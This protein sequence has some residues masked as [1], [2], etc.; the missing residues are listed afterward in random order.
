[1]ENDRT[2]AETNRINEILAKHR[3]LRSEPLDKLPTFFSLTRRRYKEFEAS[4]DKS[5]SIDLSKPNIWM[6]DFPFIFFKHNKIQREKLKKGEKLKHSKATLTK[7]ALRKALKNNAK[8]RKVFIHER[9]AEPITFYSMTVYR[10]PVIQSFFEFSLFY[11]WTK[12]V[13]LSAEKAKTVFL[14]AAKAPF[15][16]S[17]TNNDELKGLND[18]LGFMYGTEISLKYNEVPVFEVGRKPLY[19]DAV[20]MAEE[21]LTYSQ[22][23][24]HYIKRIHKEELEA[25]TAQSM[26]H[27]LGLK[28]T[29]KQAENLTATRKKVWIKK[30]QKSIRESLRQK[31]YIV[32][33]GRIRK[34]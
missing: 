25:K 1:M 20:T 9:H 21:G 31:G 4:I 8:E 12:N 30:I 11:S 17:G 33:N 34:R 15:D 28:H 16:F 26:K 24:T 5:I 23:E 10:N 19:Q 6:S 32:Q 13:E 22:I 14:K 27:Y 7:R 2:D 3:K 18:L 29:Q